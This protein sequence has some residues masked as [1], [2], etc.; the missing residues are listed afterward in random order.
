MRIILKA[1]DFRADRFT[2]KVYLY[3]RYLSIIKDNNICCSLGIIGSACEHIKES[4]RLYIKELLANKNVT[5]FN[6]SYYHFL[7]EHSSEFSGTP[8]E[9]QRDSVYKVQFLIKKLFD[10]E[11]KTFGSVANSIDKN[12]IRVINQ[13]SVFKY[14]YIYKYQ[15][16]ED[17]KKQV[18]WLNGYG[19]LEH[20]EDKNCVNFERFEDLFNEVNEEIITFQMH[21]GGWNEIDLIEFEKIVKYLKDN[22]HTFI[23]PEQL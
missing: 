8:F 12:T 2:E 14:V 7:A 18:I 23:T 5:L 1:D 20:K 16:I 19:I 3:S 17:I 9:Y 15:C 22:K 4:T 11:I 21:P 10:Y 13:C 6:H